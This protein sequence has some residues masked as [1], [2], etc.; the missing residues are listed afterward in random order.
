MRV[1]ACMHFDDEHT[2]VR[3]GMDFGCVRDVRKKRGCE[4][5]MMDGGE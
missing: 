4:E 5:R 1:L 2:H 3:E